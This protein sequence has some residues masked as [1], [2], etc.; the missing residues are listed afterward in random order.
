MT[1]HFWLCPK[2]IVCWYG[3]W[4][5]SIVNFVFYPSTELKA[6]KTLKLDINDI[7]DSMFNSQSYF[8]K[9]RYLRPKGLELP[10]LRK[11]FVFEMP[12]V[13]VNLSALWPIRGHLSFAHGKHFPCEDKDTAMCEE[14]AHR[15]MECNSL[16]L[17]MNS[18]GI[19]TTLKDFPPNSPSKCYR[20]PPDNY[21]GGDWHWLSGKLLCENRL[22]LRLSAMAA[23]ITPESVYEVNDKE[24]LSSLNRD[25][26]IW[27]Y[28]WRSLGLLWSGHV[29]KAGINCH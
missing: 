18:Q 29:S 2:F 16:L 19:V 25:I 26:V 12:S 4:Y 27:G 1:V 3:E 8:C 28:A 14:W 23:G 17:S 9:G 13:T 24:V 11:Y 15:M 22:T 20:L 6:W 10:V 21:E 5:Q 7:N